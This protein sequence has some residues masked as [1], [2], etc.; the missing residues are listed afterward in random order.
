MIQCPYTWI[1]LDSSIIQ[2]SREKDHIGPHTNPAPGVTTEQ[3]ND[4]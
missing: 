2:C 1:L 4:A 3:V